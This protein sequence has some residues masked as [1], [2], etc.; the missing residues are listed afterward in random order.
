MEL[1]G[2]RIILGVTGSIAAYK[3]VYLL[4]LLIKEGAEV[5]VIMT[6]AAK[7]FVGPPTFSALSGNSVLSDFFASEG[8]D[9]NSHVDLGVSADLMLVA[10]L[11]ATTLGKMAHGVADNLLV[12]TYLSARCPV[13]VAPAMDMDMYRHPSTQRNLDI[14]RGYGNQVIEPGIGELA[15]GLEGRG[16]MEEPEEIVNFIRQLASEPSKKKLLNKRVLVTAGPTHENIDPVRFIGNH[17]SGKMGKAIAEAFAAEGASVSLILGPVSLETHL[18]GIEVTRVTSASEMFDACSALME[19]MDVAVFNAAVSDYTPAEPSGKKLK[20]GEGEW[21]LR[22]E[23]TRD[24]AAEMGRRK[25]EGQ[26]LVGFA[27]ETDNEEQHALSK[28]KKKNLD[29]VVL[30]SMQDVGAGFGTD[31]NRVTMID[32][33]GNSEKYELKPKSQVASDLVQRVIKMMDDA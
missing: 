20:R 12:T 6:A 19:Q 29:L 31:T 25:T 33:K 24:I 5:Q 13:I 22:L 9:W 30:N 27:L 8:G 7:E 23:P 4:R 28:L 10:P 21:I 16:R 2:K 15:S 14:L 3:A 32:R 18:A 1:A 26:V 11:T 17:S